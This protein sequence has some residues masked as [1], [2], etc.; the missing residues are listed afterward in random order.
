VAEATTVGRDFYARSPLAVAPELLGLLLVTA[1]GRQA[2]LVE[3]EAYGGAEDP[4]SHAWRGRTARN[5]TMWGPPGHLYIYFSYGMHW[6]AN[7]V[8]GEDGAAGA[9]LLRAAVPEA[10][11]D[12]MRAARWQRAQRRQT[13]RDLCRGPGRLCQALGLGA[14]HGGADLTVAGGTVWIADDGRRPGRAA[15]TRRIG[16]SRGGELP[17][18]FVVAGSPWASGP[19]RHR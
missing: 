5:A 6:C 11:L 16:I 3:V 15:A 17:W 2:R 7:A 10:G 19:P 9:V 8:C 12:L 1:D 4:G 14:G 13:D 18:R